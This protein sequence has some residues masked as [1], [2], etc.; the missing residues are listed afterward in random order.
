[1]Y[2][3]RT[4]AGKQS[5]YRYDVTLGGIDATTIGVSG[6]SSTGL[7]DF[8]GFGSKVAPSAFEIGHY[9]IQ[10]N[11]ID[12]HVIGKP[13]DGVHLSVEN[14]WTSAPYNARQGTDYFAPANR[15]VAG[16]QRYEMG[17]L[18][19][20]QSVSID[21]MLSILTGTTVTVTGGGGGGGNT[22]TGSC[23]GGSSQIGG[24]DFEINGITT[25][26]TFFGEESEAD[27]TEISARIADGEFVLPNFAQPGGLS[28][29]W[30]LKFNGSYTGL[31]KLKFNYDPAL[32]P[33]GFDAHK[34][35]IWHYTKG[36]WEQLVP[37]VDTV[38][39][40]LTVMTSSLSPFM[41]GVPTTNAIPTVNAI[42]TG[43]GNQQLSWTSDTTG[44]ILQESADLATWVNSAEVV[45]TVGNVSTVNITGGGTT[46]FYRLAH[47]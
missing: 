16:A 21:V 40:V 38:N 32:L 27:D 29:V 20:G 31:I 19:A 9:G 39:H 25:E 47:P 13:S 22:G 43:G 1:M 17:T 42:H 8:I 36:A 37:V 2:D 10:G 34:L 12:D 35:T 33:P 3:N 23:K 18:A 30:N 15:W 6:S 26:G 46:Y 14:N 45:T 11:G 44:W 4:Y 28:Q 24:V 41:L 5:E 7:E